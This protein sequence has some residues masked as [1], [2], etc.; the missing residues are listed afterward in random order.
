MSAS[1]M[2]SGSCCAIQLRPPSLTETFVYLHPKYVSNLQIKTL[3]L[4]FITK[5][6]KHNR[7]NLQHSCPTPVCGPQYTPPRLI[8]STRT[9]ILHSVHTSASQ[10]FLQGDRLGHDLCPNKAVHDHQQSE[11]DPL[12]QL[13]SDP[14]AHFLSEQLQA[15]KPIEDNLLALGKSGRTSELYAVRIMKTGHSLVAKSFHQND[16]EWLQ[17]EVAVYKQLQS[18]QGQVIPVYCG[19]LRLSQPVISTQGKEFHHLLLLSWSGNSLNRRRQ[20]EP[21]ELALKLKPQLMSAMRDIH[22]SQ[23][24]HGD[25]ERRNI[26]YD[27]ISGRV[28]LVDF[29]RSRMY[30]NRPPCD[31]TKPCQKS[32][33]DGR[34]RRKLCTYCR[35]IW[36]AE[37]ALLVGSPNSS[38]ELEYKE[39][40]A[41]QN[42]DQARGRTVLKRP[43][44]SVGSDGVVGDISERN[45]ARDDEAPRRYCMRLRGRHSRD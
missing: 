28:M 1:G 45:D 31:S 29:E 42:H 13:P 15:S 22:K 23:V 14:L 37:D 18:L 43:R 24:V 30:S 33:K 40:T 16:H 38:P 5:N 3:Y 12:I 6:C 19:S 41:N 11:S 39:D 36:V 25:P 2:N 44:D 4:C 26:L 20:T 27:Q 9:W 10:I 35:D 8:H 34:G 21:Q 7:S 32:R 17:N